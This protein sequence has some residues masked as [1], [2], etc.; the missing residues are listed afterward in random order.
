MDSFVFYYVALGNNSSNKKSKLPNDSDESESIEENES[1]TSSSNSVIED[2]N[3]IAEIDESE[4][5]E[6]PK[7]KNSQR[8]GV[9]QRTLQSEKENEKKKKIHLYI[10]CRPI[11][12]FSI[13]VR[14]TIP[15]FVLQDEIMKKVTALYKTKIN[16]LR[17]QLNGDSEVKKALPPDFRV[18]ELLEEDDE[19]YVEFG[20]PTD[21]Y[22]E[23]DEESTE[24]KEKSPKQQVYVC[25]FKFSGPTANYELKLHLQNS[26]AKKP[27]NL[28]KSKKGEVIR[29]PMSFF[30]LHDAC[31]HI[32]SGLAANEKSEVDLR[33]FWERQEELIQKEEEQKAKQSEKNY[34]SSKEKETE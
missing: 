22:W 13:S 31:Y 33:T 1:K 5:P 3:W 9:P 6:K 26:F 17:L 10:D 23:G 19:V 12:K 8:Q 16:V 21:D 7:E 18:E 32:Q 34:K 20:T 14:K 30:D 28:P 2:E 27:A 29:C 25:P 11:G 4:F 24:P 15:I